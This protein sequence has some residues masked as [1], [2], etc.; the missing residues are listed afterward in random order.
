MGKQ[1]ALK[2]NNPKSPR[3]EKCWDA[4]GNIFYTFSGI[5]SAF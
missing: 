1:P 5:D 4:I 2:K 3:G